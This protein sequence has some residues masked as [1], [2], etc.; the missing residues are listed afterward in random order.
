[1]SHVRGLLS[2]KIVLASLT[3]VLGAGIFLATVPSTDAI[4]V[5]GLGVTFYYSSPALTTVV[6]AR[7]TGCCGAIINWG[8]ITKYK[9][10]ER[11]YCTD[12]VCPN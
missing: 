3:M 4:V 7:G 2:R 1:M 10:F 5:S 8:I 12:Q 6:G 11:I 9:K